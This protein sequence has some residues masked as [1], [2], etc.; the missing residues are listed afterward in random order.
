M[1]LYKY[2]A[3]ERIDV[4]QKC[5]LRYTQPG[6]F[7]DP[8]EV[9]P[10]V[11]KLAEK[12]EAQSMLE[13]AAPEAIRQVYQESPPEFR[14]IISYETFCELAKQ[15]IAG[16]SDLIF[17]MIEIFTPIIRQ[18]FAGKF[19]EMLGILS[20]SEKPDNLL[21]WAHYSGCH[22]GYVIGFDSEHPY[23]HDKQDPKDDLGHLRKVEYRETRAVTPVIDPAGV[24]VFLVKSS[25]WA[26]EQEWRIVRPLQD[27][28]GII[29]AEPFSIHLFQFPGAAVREV[30]L[31]CRMHE[32]KKRDTISLISSEPHF[33]H[34]R[35]LQADP[36]EMEFKMNFRHLTS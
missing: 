7:N 22:E 4:L 29:E 25:Q 9:T 33:Q 5:L 16:S 23:F 15:K 1:M 31:G 17:G 32:E 8:F 34:V 14:A 2:L 28:Q 12:R 20:L 27:A 13:K 6:A 11:S 19:N 24:E 18:L 30:I 35:I 10:Y 21:M 26:Y 3:P 36:D